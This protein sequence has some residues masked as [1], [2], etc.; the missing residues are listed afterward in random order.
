MKVSVC[1]AKSICGKTLPAVLSVQQLAAHSAGSG[2][3]CD[4]A[5]RNH[6]YQI[7]GR[8]QLMK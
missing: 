1:R 7:V 5:A 6:V 4:I 8:L 2:D 3:S